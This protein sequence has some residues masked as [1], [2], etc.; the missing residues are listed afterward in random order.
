MSSINSIHD[1]NLNHATIQPTGQGEGEKTLFC[2][3]NR[4][5]R[6][7]VDADFVACIESSCQG[8]LLWDDDS[9]QVTDYGRP[10]TFEHPVE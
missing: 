3:A 6:L 10:V 8:D 9:L 4:V 7:P 5:L 1:Y 2:G